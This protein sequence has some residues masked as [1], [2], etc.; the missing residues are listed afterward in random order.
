MVVQ[1]YHV[2]LT[3]SKRETSLQKILKFCTRSTNGRRAPLQRHWL[4]KGSGSWEEPQLCGC[5]L[6]LA[7]C[8]GVRVALGLC[9]TA[10]ETSPSK[11]SKNDTPIHK[12][13]QSLVQPKHV[14]RKFVICLHCFA[15]RLSSSQE[16]RPPRGLIASSL[17]A[18]PSSSAGSA[19]LPAPPQCG[20][21]VALGLLLNQ[22]VQAVVCR[23]CDP[24]FRRRHEAVGVN[25]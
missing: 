11:M 25:Y 23:P 20:G 1:V 24:P 17:T 5:V 7:G 18:P 10:V 13:R 3:F 6:V 22:S 21:G 2:R 8:P 16:K 9:A 15:V 12:T 19:G 14:V 4:P